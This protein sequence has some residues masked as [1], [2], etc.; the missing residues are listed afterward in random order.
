MYVC[1][2]ECFWFFSDCVYVSVYL[3]NTVYVCLYV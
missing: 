2:C 1:K 3:C